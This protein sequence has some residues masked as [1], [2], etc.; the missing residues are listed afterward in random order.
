[1]CILLIE[2]VLREDCACRLRDAVNVD[3]FDLFGLRRA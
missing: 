2:I 1:M 3:H